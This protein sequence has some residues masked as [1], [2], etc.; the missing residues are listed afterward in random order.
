MGTLATIAI[1][2]IGGIA[3]IYELYLYDWDIEKLMFKD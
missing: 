3:I 2:I 1:G